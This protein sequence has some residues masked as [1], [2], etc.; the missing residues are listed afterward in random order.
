VDSLKAGGRLAI[1]ASPEPVTNIT[2]VDV[3]VLGVW[4]RWRPA[5]VPG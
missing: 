4:R 1:N 5:P 3:A 2:V